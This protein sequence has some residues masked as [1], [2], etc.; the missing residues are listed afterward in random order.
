[1]DAIWS[2]CEDLCIEAINAGSLGIA[3]VITDNTGR[4]VA[5]GRNQ[6][7]DSEESCN[8]VRN[9]VVSHAELNALAGLEGAER[10]NRSL[11]LYT[12]VEPCP[13]CLGAL[14]MSFIKHLT[15]ASRDDHAGALSLLK[16]DAYLRRKRFT[17]QYAGG[18][19][20]RLFAALHVYSVDRTALVGPEHRF[21]RKFGQRYGEIL[22]RVRSLKDDE[23]I[24]AALT[25]HDHRTIRLLLT[26]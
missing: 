7:F 2:V 16:K 21:F 19:W 9:T 24:R 18:E 10:R 22:R 8:K 13:M 15:V 20:E 3:A 12:T 26:P 17:V 5:K 6:L 11:R 14:S 1:M 25:A 23:Q 4:I